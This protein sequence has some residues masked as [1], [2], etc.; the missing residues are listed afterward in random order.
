MTPLQLAW[1]EAVRRR[2]GD[3]RLLAAGA[4]GNLAVAGVWAMSRV[5]GVP[6]G[7]E[8]F[9][10]EPVGLKDVLATLDELA[11]AA[12]VALLLLRRGES[13]AVV[14]CA[15]VLVVVSVLAAFLGGHY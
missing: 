6:V 5:V 10:A 12:L 11:I 2:P 9:E 4:A 13:P 3:R 14:A 8:R 15:W 1:A 7:P